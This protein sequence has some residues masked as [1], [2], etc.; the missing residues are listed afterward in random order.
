MRLLRADDFDQTDG[1]TASLRAAVGECRI[2]HARTPNKAGI[3]TQSGS[4][5][6]LVHAH[7]DRKCFRQRNYTDTAGRRL[8]LLIEY[9]DQQHA[10][11]AHGRMIV[12]T[13]GDVLQNVQ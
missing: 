3:R 2:R 8:F 6:S 13:L 5:G 11:R 4:F 12:V 7:Q 1:M 10:V 9:A